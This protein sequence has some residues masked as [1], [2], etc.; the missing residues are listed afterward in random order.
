MLTIFFDF[1]SKTPLY[2]QLYLFIKR[3]IQDNELHPDEKLPSKRKLATHLKISVITVE[4]AYNQLLAEGYIRSVPKSGFFVQ[5]FVKLKPT[6]KRKK[7]SNL[8]PIQES[9]A[10]DFRTNR[11]DVNHFPYDRFAKIEREVMLDQYQ[12]SINQSDYLGVLQLR[13]RIAELLFEYRGIEVGPESIVIGSG[14]EHLISLLVLLLGRN[15]VYGVEEPGYLKN[16]RLY[17]DYG[18]KAKTI[19][20]DEQGIQVKG[21]GDATVVHVTP[22]H[23]FPKGIVTT[24]Q[25]R[26]E[27]LNWAY[28]KS[29]HYIIEDDYDSEFRFSGIPIPAMKSLDQLDR[30]IYMNSFSKSISPSFRVSFMVLPDLLMEQYHK[31]YSYFTCSVP[32][33]TQLVLARFIQNKEYERHLNRMK[34]L[35]KNKRDYLIALLKNSVFGSEIEIIGEESGLHFLLEVSSS[36]SAKQWID[37]S[38]RYGVRMYSLG[39]YRLESTASS[40][41]QTIVLGYSHLSLEEMDDA[42]KR[43]ADAWKE[44][45]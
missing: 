32:V 1:Q 13:E 44:L 33:M 24:I 29:N 23:Q 16:Y 31:Y 19:A 43:L 11:V 27:L 35:Y 34:N 2:E 20:L 17:L 18:A 26:M 3:A 36:K 45:F 39:E 37:R 14:S 12:A 6:S 22:S 21:I 10:I 30:V 28:E 38:K 5:P 8:L 15:Q 4:T 7:T 9:F 41:D 40:E 25:R 42:T